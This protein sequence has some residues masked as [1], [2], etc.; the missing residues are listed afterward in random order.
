MK[1]KNIYIAIAS[2]FLT[3]CAEPWSVNTPWGQV[4]QDADGNVS[5]SYAPKAPVIESVK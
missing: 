4:T 5:G 3:S 2:L 1:T